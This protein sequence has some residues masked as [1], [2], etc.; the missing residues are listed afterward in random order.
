MD[1]PVTLPKGRRMSDKYEF[2]SHGWFE[3]LR[4]T[5]ERTVRAAGPEIDE[6]RWSACEVFV[7]V[8]AHLVQTDDGKA[9]WH[10]RVRGRDVEF[11]LGEIDDADLKIV[12]DYATA[13]PLARVRLS[14]LG[15]QARV[16]EALAQAAMKGL[17]RIHGSLEARPP[18][19]AGLHDAMVAVTA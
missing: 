8:P 7:A 9:A 3:A 11:G 10:C 18:G 12:A 19:L 5:I 15:A 6:V 2:A 1:G 17:L 13:L 14:D 4:R 16:D